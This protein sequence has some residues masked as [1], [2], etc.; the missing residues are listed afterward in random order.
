MQQM[1]KRKVSSGIKSRC[2]V[3]GDKFDFVSASFVSI[4]N[5]CRKH[6][7]TQERSSISKSKE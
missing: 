1:P 3:C 7:E 2:I 4:C 6:H 5:D